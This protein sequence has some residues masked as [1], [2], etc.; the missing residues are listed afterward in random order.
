MAES[1]ML[2]WICGGRLRAGWQGVRSNLDLENKDLGRGVF[3]CLVMLEGLQAVEGREHR[4][5]Y[6][7]RD[8]PGPPVSLPSAEATN[9]NPSPRCEKAI[10][11]NRRNCPR[12]TVRRH[13]LRSQRTGSIAASVIQSLPAW[14]GPGMGLNSLYKRCHGR[15]DVYIAL[16]GVS[17]PGSPLSIA[18]T[19]G[20][21]P[22]AHRLA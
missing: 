3:W 17:G 19:E 7:S 11:Q 18:Y 6:S 22:R 14:M 10:I 20:I 21:E 5:L 4:Y 16:Y 13:P 9:I 12:P 15:I 8:H 1:C 2:G